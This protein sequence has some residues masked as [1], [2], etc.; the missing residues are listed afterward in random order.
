MPVEQFR[1][2]VAA[3]TAALC[4]IG[5]GA[6]A[7]YLWALPP[8]DPPRELALIFGV[9]GTLIGSGTTFLFVAEGASRATHAAERS[10]AN[11]SASGATL[12]EQISGTVTSGTVTT[13]ATTTANP[14]EP[15]PPPAIPDTDPV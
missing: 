8:I 1:G 12:P 13:T 6:A 10:F 9:I 11:G 5:G 3:V 2:Y 14:D 4:V 7:V 15:P